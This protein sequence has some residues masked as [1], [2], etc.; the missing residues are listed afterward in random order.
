MVQPCHMPPLNSN[1]SESS[2]SIWTQLM[3]VVYKLLVSAVSLSGI[4]R[5][6]KPEHIMVNK[7]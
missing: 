4:P 2:P 3:V 1:E 6:K 5:Q 7:V